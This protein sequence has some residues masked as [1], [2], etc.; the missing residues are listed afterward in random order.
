MVKEYSFINPDKT[1]RNNLMAFGYECGEGWYKLIECCFDRIEE[2]IK[3][4]EQ[5]VGLEILQV[6]EKFG[7]LRIYYYG[8]DD[9]IE[10]LIRE[11][12]KKSYEICESCGSTQNVSTKNLGW[13]YTR[14][15][16]CFKDMEEKNLISN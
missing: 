10:N 1:F 2:Y 12:C 4:H 11:T 15:E 5:E 6:K 9:Y 16:K 13:V 14:C 3:E 8:G 7:G